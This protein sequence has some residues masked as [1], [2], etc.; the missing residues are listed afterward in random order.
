MEDL[1]VRREEAKE[2]DLSEPDVVDSDFLRLA[3]RHLLRPRRLLH[4]SL[5]L[6]PRALLFDPRSGD[7]L[8]S[9]EPELFLVAF[10]LAAVQEAELRPDFC[11]AGVVTQ[12]GMRAGPG[13]ATGDLFLQLSMDTACTAPGYISSYGSGNLLPSYWFLLTT[14]QADQVSCQTKSTPHLLSRCGCSSPAGGAGG[15][16]VS[17]VPPRPPWCRISTHSWSGT[18]P[19]T[20]R[21]GRRRPRGKLRWRC[22]RSRSCCLRHRFQ[23]FTASCLAAVRVAPGVSSSPPRA[24]AS[25]W[26][27]STGPPPLRP[28]PPSSSSVARSRSTRQ[29]TQDIWNLAI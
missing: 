29:T 3:A 2:A 26:L 19:P 28:A 23:S 4:G 10:P 8:D 20:G 17:P 25:P 14:A 1:L 18:P 7:P 21:W 13:T 22:R 27:R 5:L 6:T 12:A 9:L 24:T 11:G 15:T 16:A